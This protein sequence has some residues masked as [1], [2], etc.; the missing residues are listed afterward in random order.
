MSAHG[1]ATGLWYLG[2]LSAL[3]GMSKN[4]ESLIEKVA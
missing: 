3:V 4:E 2:M 1:F